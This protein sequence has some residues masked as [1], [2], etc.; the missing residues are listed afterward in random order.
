METPTVAECLKYARLQMAAEAFIRSETSLILA[1]SGD[2]LIGA[3]ERG[4]GHASKFR[5]PILLRPAP[6]YFE[7][8]ALRGFF[9]LRGSPVGR[10]L[11]AADS[12]GHATH[13]R[14]P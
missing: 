8:P 12:A 13:A 14:Y 5:R 1:K 4:N 9:H 10:L 6:H 11:W 2:D 3:L 7:G